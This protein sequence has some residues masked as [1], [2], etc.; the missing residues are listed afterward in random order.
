MQRDHYTKS[1]K[2]IWLIK[3]KQKIE[4]LNQS[5]KKALGE[6][7]QKEY[8]GEGIIIEDV[9]LDPSMQYGRVWLVCTTE[10]LDIIQKNKSNIQRLV[11]K[12]LA[13]RYTPKI[14]FLISDDY[15]GKIDNLFSEVDNED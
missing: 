2:N 4:Q 15:L 14:D 10:Q 13:T 6:V 3:M 1:G 9:L 11:Q 5:Y 8:S 12:H 7:I